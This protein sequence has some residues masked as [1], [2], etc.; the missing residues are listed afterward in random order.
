MKNQL[1]VTEIANSEGI[2]ILYMELINNHM[3][4]LKFVTTFLNVYDLIVKAQ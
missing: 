1:G 4:I 2:N 3:D